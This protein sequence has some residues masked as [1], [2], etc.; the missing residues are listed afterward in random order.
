MLTTSLSRTLTHSGLVLLTLM[1]GITA[2]RDSYPERLRPFSVA[3]TATYPLTGNTV[4]DT[5]Y[6]GW[7]NRETWAIGLHLMDSV[8]EWINDDK[9]AWSKDDTKDAATI[10]Q[11]LVA[12]QMEDAGLPTYPL[13][14]DLLDLSSVNWQELGRSALDSVFD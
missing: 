6:N 4:T 5:T 10:F 1:S 8:V 9:D 11:D 3:F 13:L 14:W 2:L 12:E 7:T